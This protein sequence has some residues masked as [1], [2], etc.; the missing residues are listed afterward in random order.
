MIIDACVLI[1]LIKADR[2]ALG[3]IV[4]HI[5]PL[6]VITSV[7][8]E[9]EQISEADL[10]DLGLTILEPE[11]EDAREAGKRSG[12]L[13][14]EDR[15]CLLTARR[16]GLTCVTNDKSLRRAC[17]SE[18]IPLLWGL[19]PIIDLHKA[20]ALS[21][22][23][24]EAIARAIHESNPKHITQDILARFMKALRSS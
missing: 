4:K 10:M 18:D 1:D 15:L 2:S 6:Y 3:L 23:A 19:E 24:A 21:F 12:A 5:G 17:E 7:V 8:A 20:D 16:H 9:V 11:I 14:F 22:E 13:S